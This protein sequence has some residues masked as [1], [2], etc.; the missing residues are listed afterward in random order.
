AVAGLLRRGPRGLGIGVL[1]AAVPGLGMTVIFRNGAHW[2][3][4]WAY[5]LIFPAGFAVAYLV[6]S[7]R[8]TGRRR[9]G[10]APNLVL[11]VQAVLAIRAAGD[12]LAAERLLNSN[13]GL[14]RDYFG[15]HPLP[16]VK[17]M[18]AYEFHPYVSWYLRVPTE[19]ALSLEQLRARLA[20][21]AWGP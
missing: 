18:T 2:H 14:A 6:Q 1:L 7:M 19:S 5:N 10:V 3:A 17:M 9:A 20:S 11:G 13:G 21:G 15:A 4:F 8:D 12:Q 16:V